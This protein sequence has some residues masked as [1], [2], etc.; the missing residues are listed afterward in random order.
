MF[1][2]KQLW[3]PPLPRLYAL[4]IGVSS[5]EV[6]TD[7]TALEVGSQPLPIMLPRQLLH[8]TKNS[9]LLLGSAEGV[10]FNPS[11]WLL[12][13]QAAFSVLKESSGDRVLPGH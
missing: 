9:A 6:D 2:A 10:R 5:T 1:E 3:W 7:A 4:L 11:P 13:L 8:D 12:L